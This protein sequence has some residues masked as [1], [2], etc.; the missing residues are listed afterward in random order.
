M[1]KVSIIN[2]MITHTQKHTRHASTTNSQP[3][4]RL[5]AWADLAHKAKTMQELTLVFA[6]L[7][8]ETYGPRNERTAA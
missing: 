5:D 1:P 4:T 7:L 6:L 2:D 3:A 8:E